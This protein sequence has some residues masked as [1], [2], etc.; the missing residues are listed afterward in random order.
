MR[1]GD[2][3]QGLETILQRAPLRMQALAIVRSLDLPDWAIG[4]GFIRAAVWD[5]LSGFT[6]ASAVDDI[7]ILYFDAADRRTEREA[8]IE[9]RLQEIEPALPWSVRNQ[10]RM[11]IRN[12]DAPY[13]STADALRF[14]LET[15]TCVAVRLDAE[16]RFEIIAPYGL[17]DLFSMTIRPTP[18]GRVRSA[19]YTARIAEKKWHERWPNVTVELP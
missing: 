18:R 6:T 9:K 12:G 10:A 11:H 4:A 16:D 19:A 7:D 14:W 2:L 17:E 5:A 13:A 1:E 15:P 3:R 8:E